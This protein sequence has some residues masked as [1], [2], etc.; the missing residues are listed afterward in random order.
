M[1]AAYVPRSYGA[2]LM[3][4]TLLDYKKQRYRWAYGAMQILK[5]HAGSLFGGRGR[6]SLG[7]RYH[8]LAGWLPWLSD[9]FN[10]VFNVAA[11]FWSVGMVF[12][13]HSIDPPLMIFSALP[14]ALFAFKI[15][16][17]LHLYSTRVGAT[18]RQTLAA[19]FAGLALS[20]TIGGAVLAGL[21]T[22]DQPFFRTPKRAHA[23]ALL[24]ALLD[25][26]EE[27]LIMLGLWLAAFGSYYAAAEV[28]RDQG[29]SAG[30]RDQGVW[31][32]VLLIQSVPYFAA[33][34]VS[35]VSAFP[36]LPASWIGRAEDMDSL[37]HQVLD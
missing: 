16:K 25:C 13:P 5:H 27:A 1:D 14:L 19:A 17:L 30:M 20:H 21:F 15:A 37:A 33:V 34:L 9:G 18:P 23:H 8:F 7:Q 31:T 22:H 28:M 2:G 3:P 35:L 10:L 29:V 4:D 24:Q 26:R 12:F 36:A 6:L 32:L 11:I